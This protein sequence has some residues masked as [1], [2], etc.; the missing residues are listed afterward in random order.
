LVPSAFAVQSIPEKKTTMALSFAQF[1]CL[2]ATIIILGSSSV[3]SEDERVSSKSLRGLQTLPKKSTRI[4]GGFESEKGRFP[5]YAILNQ[6]SLCGAVLLSPRFALTAAHCQDAANNLDIAPQNSFGGGREI[7]FE[8]VKGHPDYDIFTYE[9][10][11][12]LLELKEDAMIFANGDLVPAGTVKLSPDP[13]DDENLTMTVI[14]FGDVNPDD[15]QTDFAD[16][17]NQVDVKYVNNDECRRDHRGEITEEMM[18]AEAPG[19]DACYGDSGGPLLLTSSDDYRDDAVVG[20]VSWGRGCADAEFPGVY[21]RISFF[22]DWITLS[23]C[24]MNRKYAPPYVNCTELL[25]PTLSPSEAPTMAASEAPTVAVNTTTSLVPQCK[26]RNAPCQDSSECCSRRCNVI[27]KKM[28]H[29][30]GW[31]PGPIVSGHWGCRWGFHPTGKP[32]GSH[33]ARKE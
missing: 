28:Q 9:N 33:R 1:A 22:Y 25:G 23:M 21:T 4:I 15:R 12:A 8:K 16:A 20:V 31:K 19:K 18:C 11:I 3:R 2:A 14:G 27:N 7:V 29:G 10:D 5:Y 17:L 24:E 32:K 26:A 30:A 13:I 6:K